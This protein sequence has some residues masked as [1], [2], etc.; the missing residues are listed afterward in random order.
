[1]LWEYKARL[2]GFSFGIL[3]LASY[4]FMQAGYLLRYL[5]LW[6]KCKRDCELN[7]WWT[8]CVLLSWA[9]PDFLT[10]T[11]AG[12]IQLNLCC[13]V[14]VKSALLQSGIHIHLSRLRNTHLAL[15]GC[16]TLRVFADLL[17]LRGGL[18]E[19]SGNHLLNSPQDTL[20]RFL[21]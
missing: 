14:Q 13:C 8:M 11:V 6:D 20:C 18:L 15:I 19:G 12:N 2:M 5:E 10:C 16:R 21:E 1:M 4:F 3:A 17:F 9:A 7:V